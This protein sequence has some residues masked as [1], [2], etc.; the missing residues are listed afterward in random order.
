IDEDPEIELVDCRTGISALYLA[1]DRDRDALSGT[2]Q[3]HA[4]SQAIDLLHGSERHEGRVPRARTSFA[5]GRSVAG[6]PGRTRSHPP[7]TAWQHS[8]RWDRTRLDKAKV[9]RSIYG[10]H[11]AAN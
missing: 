1:D 11:P 8:S 5:F 2:F 7:P 10:L 9:M 4:S 3:R 6:F